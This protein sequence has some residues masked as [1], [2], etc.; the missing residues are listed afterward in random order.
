MHGPNDQFQWRQTRGFHCFS[1]LIRFAQFVTFA[2]TC[3]EILLRVLICVCTHCVWND[4]RDQ[5]CSIHYVGIFVVVNHFLC[6]F[7]ERQTKYACFVLFFIQIL[8]IGFVL[9]FSSPAFC[10]GSSIL[11]N[12]LCLCVRARVCFNCA[13]KSPAKYFKMSLGGKMC[14]KFA[15]S[16]KYTDSKKHE[17]ECET[18]L[19]RTN[20]HATIRELVRNHA[21]TSK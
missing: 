15:I 10:S 12:F 5:R 4:S 11:G 17:S 6:V 18:T 7:P 16:L 13:I 1:L 19:A 9:V 8:T 2:P 20:K 3:I 14:P 21:V